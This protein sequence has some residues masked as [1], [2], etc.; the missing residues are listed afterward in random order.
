MTTAT[1]AQPSSVPAM[2]VSVCLP[3]PLTMA[4]LYGGMALQPLDAPMAAVVG[5]AATLGYVVAFLPALLLFEP[6]A[7]VAT[8]WFT[9]R[10]LRKWG[11]SAMP[12]IACWM[13]VILHTA[14]LV[15]Y[16]RLGR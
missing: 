5:F 2:V 11:E 13:A 1:A 9:A 8:L 10:Y 4:A 16:L 14:V 15:S 7:V 3:L 12:V 6:F